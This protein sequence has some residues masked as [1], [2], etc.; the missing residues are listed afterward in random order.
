MDHLRGA[1]RGADRV[2][3]ALEQG[4]RVAAR[5][6]VEGDA[7]AGDAA[8]D[9]DDLEALR[10]RSPRSPRR[11]SASA[12]RLHAA[13]GHGEV[14][15]GLLGGRGARAGPAPGAGGRGGAGRR[16]ARSAGSP[17]ARP[18]S[19]ARAAAPAC[20][21][22]RRGRGRGRRAGR[23]RRRRR[24]RAGPP[25][26]GPGRRRA[27]RRRRSG[28]ARGRASAAP[29]GPAASFRRSQRRRADHAEAPGGG[30]V[31]VR[32][33]AGQL[34]QLLEL[35]PGERLGRE[36]L[37]GAAG[38]DRGLDVHVENIAALGG[39]ARSYQA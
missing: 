30:Q 2:V 14:D 18:P 29:S 6:G 13:R 31:V 12:R 27:P 21:S 5:G 32:R 36:G 33:P 34:E 19:G 8:A 28:S 39:G 37:V 26:P 38:P 25:R 35:L 1:A 22:S 17:T 20:A 11:G 10:R 15:R 4:H 3:A 7:G 23:C 24:S 9:D 16:S